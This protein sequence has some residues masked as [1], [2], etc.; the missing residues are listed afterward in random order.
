MKNFYETIICDTHSCLSASGW[1][2]H[3]YGNWKYAARQITI[4]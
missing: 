3:V 2:Y 4:L 1:L